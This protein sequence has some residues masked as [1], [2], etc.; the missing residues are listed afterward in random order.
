MSR[1]T[2]NRFLKFRTIKKLYRNGYV[3]SYHTYNNK[4]WSNLWALKRALNVGRKA[5]PLGRFGGGRGCALFE[6]TTLRT[7]YNQGA[8]SADLKDD[9]DYD[10]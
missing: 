6:Q 1:K 5:N 7:F 2:L 3:K 10:Y 8:C 9:A 4:S